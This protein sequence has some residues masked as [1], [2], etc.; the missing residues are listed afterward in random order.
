MNKIKLYKVTSCILGIISFCGFMLLLGSIGAVEH[1]RIGMLQFLNQMIY[2]LLLFVV[3]EI[4][5]ILAHH[6][7]EYLSKRG[8]N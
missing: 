7:Y 2:G 8:E 6:Q 5:A 1:N 4:G 3:G